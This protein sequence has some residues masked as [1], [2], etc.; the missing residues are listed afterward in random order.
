[1]K[2]AQAFDGLEAPMLVQTK[3]EVASREGLGGGGP[4]PVSICKS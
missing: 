1:M 4:K 2:Y 3:F